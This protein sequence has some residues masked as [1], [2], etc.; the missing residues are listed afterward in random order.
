MIL[1]QV[2]NLFK[3]PV[4]GYFDDIDV[5]INIPSVSL[6]PD[7]ADGEYNLTWWDSTNY[8]DPSDD[9]NVEI[10]RVTGRDVGAGTITVTRA[11]ETTLA[12]AKDTAGATY[13]MIN[14][15][16]RKT[17]EDINSAI[18]VNGATAKTTP[19]DAD[20]V[21]LID[22]AASNVLKKLTWANLKATLKNYFDSVTTTLAN[23]TLT[24]PVLNTGFSG[25]AKATGAEITT[26]TDDTKIVTPKA[27]ADATVGKLGSAWAAWTPT[28]T[29]LTV[30]NGTLICK[31]S[32][33]G[34]TITARIRFTLGTTSSVGTNPYFSLPVPANAEYTQSG[35]GVLYIEDLATA[36]FAGQ[37]YMRSTTTGWLLVNKVD[38]VNITGS[39]FEA[40]IPFT[41]TTGDYFSGTFTYE[42]V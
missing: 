8:P 10:V 28:F 3:K 34:K 2:V 38:G 41:W 7:P 11:Q 35:I 39:T 40:T 20:L 4:T 25:T 13:M 12:S 33:V 22:S 9:P 23:K 31:Y 36:G 1:D 14:A 32:Q 19:V 26:G 37:I 17:I 24:N 16:T 27:L 5:T 42:S 15:P 21:G 30:G 6:F 29:N 18:D